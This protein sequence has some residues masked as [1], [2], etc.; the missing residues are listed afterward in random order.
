M[1]GGLAVFWRQWNPLPEF[2]QVVSS[3]QPSDAWIVD[4]H[5]RPLESIRLQKNHRSLAWLKQD[6]IST[7][8]RDTLIAVEDQRFYHHHGVD[9]VALLHA[10]SQSLFSPMRRGASTLSMQLASLLVSV[11]GSSFSLA[12]KIR[13]IFLAW[14]LEE[15]W[16]KS[17]ILE[18]YI[19][20]IAFRG[21]LVGLRAASLG[22][23]QKS[24]IAL[25]EK[26]SALLV[27]L[28]RAPNAEI[29][30]VGWRA[31]RILKQDS[32]DDILRMAQ[33][34]FSQPYDLPRARE[35]MPVLA[36]AFVEEGWGTSLIQTSLDARIQ[37]AALSALREQLTEL[38]AQNVLDGAILVLETKTGRPVAYVANGGPGRSSAAQI[39]GIQMRRQAGS[40]IK[41]FVYA[42]AFEKKYLEPSSLIQDSPADVPVGQGKVYHPKNYDNTFR[43]LVSAGEA[44]ASSLNVPAVRTLQ[45]VGEEAV[46]QNLK[47]LHFEDLQ[48]EDF[49]GPSLAL[50]TVDVS[51]WELTQGYRQLALAAQGSGDDEVFSSE[52]KKKIFQVLALPEYRR[53]TFGLESVLSLPFLA[54]VKTGT[55]KDMRDNWCVGW[56][57][58][59]T[60][61]VWVGNFNGDPMWNVSGVTGA[62]P[63]WSRMMLALHPTPP[64]TPEL[65]FEKPAPSLQKKSL[66]RIHYPVDDLVV[67]LDPDIPQHL[68]RLPVEVENPQS[69]QKVFIN[70]KLLGLAKKDLFWEPVR[71]RFKFELRGA[72][73]SLLDQVQIQVR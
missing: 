71:G 5:Q 21:E 23:F 45:L 43:G 19:N 62:A 17:Q 67:G 1:I 38:R 52:T 13:Q 22:Y 58:Q 49:Y 50:G 60:V 3:Y 61:G 30:R 14:K 7:V 54:A 47:A 57:S 11:D 29:S 10:G 44:L 31:C 70:G 73:Q 15:K 42:T 20:L 41:P 25:G 16:T 48:N 39:D 56:T 28:I 27:A 8:F 64:E 55:S 32:C 72:D 24:P 6:E 12:R 53:L 18:A 69:G 33:Q 59:Y 63:M 2:S 9:L 37:D 65:I 26:E 34:T 68:Q 4:R 66:T 51:L 46:I 36:K 40:T 35:K